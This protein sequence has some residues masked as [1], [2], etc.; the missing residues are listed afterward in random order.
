MSLKRVPRRLDDTVVDSRSS[1]PRLPE[2][3][4]RHAVRV[5]LNLSFL[6]AVVRDE[7]VNGTEY[8]GVNICETAL[9]VSR[10]LCTPD[11]ALLAGV[12]RQ[13]PLP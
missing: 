4:L 8:R 12:L 1:R 11:P 5:G 10:L 7:R 13:K 9:Q 3:G 6:Y 2:V